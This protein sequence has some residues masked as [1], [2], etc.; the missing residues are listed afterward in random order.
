[1]SSA[2][3]HSIQHWDLD[4]LTTE[5]MKEYFDSGRDCRKTGTCALQQEIN[6]QS[7]KKQPASD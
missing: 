4:V 7:I 6:A 2:K 3:R 5:E 1:M